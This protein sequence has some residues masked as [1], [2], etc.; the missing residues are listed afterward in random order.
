MIGTRRHQGKSHPRVK[1]CWDRTDSGHWLDRRGDLTQFSAVFWRSSPGFEIPIPFQNHR[2][3][4]ATTGPAP[5]EA[6]AG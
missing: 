4:S 2:T 6:A 3:R 1:A 5:L